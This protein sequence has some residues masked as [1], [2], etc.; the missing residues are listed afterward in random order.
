MSRIERRLEPRPQGQGK[1]D[2]ERW[3]HVERD[4]RVKTAILAALVAG[5]RLNRVFDTVFPTWVQ[6]DKSEYTPYDARAEKIASWVIKRYDS[7]A[8]ILGEDIS[9]N[10]NVEGENFWTIDGIDGTTN[11]ARR[12]PVCNH[13]L[14]CVEQGRT[15]I[16]VV[17]DFL[18]NGLYH[19]V[20]GGGAYLNGQP[21]HVTERPFSESVITFAPLL[22]VRKGKGAT[23]RL[24]VEAVWAGMKEI[25]ESSRRFPREFQS[26]G[27]ELAWVGS[28]KL[29]GYVSSWTNPWDLSAGALLVQEAGG[30]ATNIFGDPWRPGYYGVIAGSRTVHPEMLAILNRRRLALE[31]A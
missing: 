16:G 29:D 12:I 2:F 13:T 8:L 1:L 26:G 25:S 14:A 22:D 10:E 28:G 5:H 3:P 11:F 7:S 9:P 6:G 17:F 20:E 24:E 19:A 21:I 15:R 31:E 4:P 23:E 27:L 18:N 30:I